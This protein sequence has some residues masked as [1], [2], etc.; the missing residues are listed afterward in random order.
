MDNQEKSPEGFEAFIKEVRD[1][2]LCHGDRADWYRSYGE[3]R[4]AEVERCWHRYYLDIVLMCEYIGTF[5]GCCAHLRELEN[6]L[7]KK[8]KYYEQSYLP[9]PSTDELE[10]L[11][12][13][14]RIRLF[15]ASVNGCIMSDQDYEKC[16]TDHAPGKH[17]L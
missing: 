12:Q 15:L 13:L 8:F 11:W 5:E 6:D 17:L 14:R 1:L 7:F 9:C 16:F 3:L 10:R 2:A 4:M